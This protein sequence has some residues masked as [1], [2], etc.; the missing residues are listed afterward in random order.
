MEKMRRRMSP[1]ATFRAESRRR[2]FASRFVSVQKTTMAAAKLRHSRALGARELHFRFINR[3]RKVPENRVSPSST[4]SCLH[5]FPSSSSP[6][7][8]PTLCHIPISCNDRA[9]DFFLCFFFLPSP[10]H[11]RKVGRILLIFFIAPLSFL[12]PHALFPST[13][14]TP[15]KAANDLKEKYVYRKKRPPPSSGPKKEGVFHLE[16]LYACKSEILVGG[17]RSTHESFGESGLELGCP[18]HPLIGSY[19][20]QGTK[21]PDGLLLMTP[22]RPYRLSSLYTFIAPMANIPRLQW[23]IIRLVL[24]TLSQQLRAPASDKHSTSEQT[25]Q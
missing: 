9:V 8:S 18:L 11:W 7:S 16:S 4:V 15:R 25:V 19:S 22:A 13:V 23:C 5:L 10:R 6:S 17:L 14:K 12:L 2:L 3:W 20:S 1:E 21:A 24:S